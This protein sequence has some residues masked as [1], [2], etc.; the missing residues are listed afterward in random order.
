MTAL[1][2]SLRVCSDRSCRHAVAKIM[3]WAALNK[4]CQTVAF[5][6]LLAYVFLLRLPSE[7]LVA[8]AGRDCGQS[9]VYLEADELVIVLKRRCVF[10]SRRALW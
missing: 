6:Y 8:R 7:A 2:V 1:C 9:S 3:R 5:L 10:P 4:E